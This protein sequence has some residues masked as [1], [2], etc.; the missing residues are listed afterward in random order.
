MRS[1]RADSLRR[2]GRT[3]PLLVLAAAAAAVAAAAAQARQLPAT[4]KICALM[5]KVIDADPAWKV[6]LENGDFSQIGHRW[7]CSWTDKSGA[8]AYKYELTL[9]MTLNPSAALAHSQL[10]LGLNKGKPLKGTK[11]DEAWGNETHASGTTASR[12]VWRKGRYTGSLGVGGV[13][14][15]GDLGDARELLDGFL[16]RLPRA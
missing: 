13:G 6:R 14:L 1:P 3:V 7:T 11:A 10:A 2:R 8:L 4:P 9:A 5:Q 12:I 15:S 16:V